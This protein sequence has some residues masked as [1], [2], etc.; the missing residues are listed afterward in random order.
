MA[1]IVMFYYPP[2]RKIS[3][4]FIKNFRYDVRVYKEQLRNRTKEA[5]KLGG[6]EQGR[7]EVS[8][9]LVNFFKDWNHAQVENYGCYRYETEL[10]NPC[11]SVSYDAL[12]TLCAV[13]YTCEIEYIAEG[14]RSVSP[15]VLMDRARESHI[16]ELSKHRFAETP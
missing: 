2:G 12:S 16:K 14:A 11:V 15:V 13:E 7:E 3:P 8:Q 9:M 6:H 4:G 5:A 1:N 10:N